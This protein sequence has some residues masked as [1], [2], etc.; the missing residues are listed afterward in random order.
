MAVYTFRPARAS[1]LTAIVHFPVSEEEL[2]YFFPSARY[3]LSLSQLE[4]Q[5]KQRYHSTVML[6]NNQVIGFANF[7]NVKNHQIAFIGNVIIKPKKRSQGLGK[8]LLTTMISHAFQQLQLKEIHLSCYNSNTRALIFYTQLG[9][10]PYAIEQRMT[11]HKQP[12]ALLHLRLK[13]QQ[14]K[15][16]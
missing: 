9:F 5:L 14:G 12:V 15:V 1:D 6:E 8:K 7:Y 4:Q 10:Q 16:N 2:F 3:P 11:S 13:N